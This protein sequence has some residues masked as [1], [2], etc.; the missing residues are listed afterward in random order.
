MTPDR[1]GTHSMRR[2]EM[3]DEQIEREIQEKGFTAPRVTLEAIEAAIVGEYCFTAADGALGALSTTD[4]DPV[5]AF[6][7][8]PH[9]LHT[10]TICVLVLRNGYTVTGE[11]AP[12]SAENFDQELGRTI[13]RQHAR[14]KI[15]ALEGYAL[16]SRLDENRV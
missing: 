16:R 7:S 12:V 10:L 15:W 4:A 2:N 1:V 3:S 8:L 9:S 6:Q 11:S 5:A 14:D 13:A